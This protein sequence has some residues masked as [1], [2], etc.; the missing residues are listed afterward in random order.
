MKLQPLTSQRDFVLLYCGDEVSTTSRKSKNAS[1]QSQPPK[2]SVAQKSTCTKPQRAPAAVDTSSGDKPASVGSGSSICTD[3]SAS[4]S[5]CASSLS[6]TSSASLEKPS[7]QALTAGAKPSA[8]GIEVTQKPLAGKTLPRPHVR[9][10]RAP[11][12]RLELRLNKCTWQ[13]PQTPTQDTPAGAVG[14]TAR[15]PQHSIMSLSVPSQGAAHCSTSY[16]HE[17]PRDR[18][19]GQDLRNGSLKSAQPPPSHSTPSEGLEAGE[20]AEGSDTAKTVVA[21]KGK[22]SGKT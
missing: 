5:P 8:T 16:L 2:S 21:V 11:P 18:R 10:P 19:H 7:A 17:V 4:A 15:H 13:R 20:V 22:T 6:L 3:T 14:T 12:V 1:V 9:P